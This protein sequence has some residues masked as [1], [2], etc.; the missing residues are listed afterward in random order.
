VTAPVAFLALVEQFVNCFTA[1]GFRHFVHFMMAHATL[2]GATHCVTETLRQTRW[3]ELKHWTASY[4]FMKRGRWS[5]RAVTQTLFRVL[6]GKLS[7][8]DEADAGASVVLA[9]DDTL[10]K[11]WG[12]HFF[13]LGHYLDPTDKTPGASHRRVLGHCWVV[14]ALLWEQG[15]GRWFCFPLGALL[16]VPE[17]RCSRA[18]PF[19][20][21]IELAAALLRR[22]R[23]APRAILVVDNLYAKA[24]LLADGLR[25]GDVIVSRLRCNAALYEPPKPRKSGQRGRPAK[26]GAKKTA[27]EL[28]RRRSQR[29][30]M[31]V[32]I[33]GKCVTFDAFVGAVIP[34]RTLGERP[35]Q[36]VIFRQRSGKKMNVFFTTDLLMS[37]ERLLELYAAR[38]KI[39]DAF[40][41]LKTFGGFGDC[42]QRSLTALKRHA[43]L[44]VV[45]HSLLRLL[46]L[47]LKGAERL[48][49]EPWWQPLGPPSVTRVRRALNTAFAISC[50]LHS[51]TKVKEIRPAKHI[52]QQKQ[53]HTQLKAA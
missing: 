32:N 25:E 28:W 16:F 45:A 21:K 50:S 6:F 23:F 2:W 1:P 3:H 10:V 13:G 12:R 51:T 11:K 20:T 31:T 19:Q 7:F 42:Q 15:P 43:T 48:A 18:F 37:P 17:S 8:A 39:E 24:K 47:T 30:K 14:L 36:V 22:L 29:R 52:A 53:R 44:C 41:E 38:F 5:C 34:S 26:R 35:I 27:R 40:D 9:I 4:V 33:Y 46:A 49:A